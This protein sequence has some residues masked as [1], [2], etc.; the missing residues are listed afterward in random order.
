MWTYI[1]NYL[2]GGES[3]GA[4]YEKELQ[5]NLNEFRIENVI[6]KKSL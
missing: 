5:K 4:F 2:T 1:V 3:V 6:K